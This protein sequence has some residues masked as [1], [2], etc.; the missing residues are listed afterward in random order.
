MVEDTAVGDPNA[1]G[2]VE[3]AIQEVACV[4]RTLWPALEE[5]LGC[6]V[7]IRHP[8]TPWLGRH[9]GQLI[10]RYQ[11]SNN[12]SA[13]YRMAKGRDAIQPVCEFGKMVMFSPPKTNVLARA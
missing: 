1:N 5:R 10:T 4:T 3:R 8:L 9:A 11:V 7:G 6:E 12:G 2:R 13:S